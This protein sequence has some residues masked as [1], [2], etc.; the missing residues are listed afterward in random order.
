MVDANTKALHQKLALGISEKVEKSLNYIKGKLNSGFKEATEKYGDKLDDQKKLA[1]SALKV[2]KFYKCDKSDLMDIMNGVKPEPKI[3]PEIEE[4]LES[5]PEIDA[6]FDNVDEDDNNEDEFEEDGEIGGDDEDDWDTDDDDDWDSDEPAKPTK[7]DTIL[8]FWNTVDEKAIFK[9]SE[10][11]DFEKT[12]SLYRL[13]G[14]KYTLEL[15]DVNAAPARWT[16]QRGNEKTIWKIILHKV[17]PNEA[18]KE[19]NSECDDKEKQYKKGR[20]YSFFMTQLMYATFKVFVLKNNKKGIPPKV[21][22]FKD[23]G[24]TDK[25]R[26]TFGLTK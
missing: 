10:G 5:D 15:V 14:V 17:F 24:G 20:K 8:D 26:Y 19:Y 11:V 6:L 7:K 25:N 16:D 9:K 18:A 23:K 2:L 12:P 4:E 22:T 21:F 1:L 13:T 3:E